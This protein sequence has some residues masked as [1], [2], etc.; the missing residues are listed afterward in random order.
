MGIAVSD[1]ASP[2][3][4]LSPSRLCTRL[5]IGALEREGLSVAAI[6]RVAE[7]SQKTTDRWIGR[8]RQGEGL[9]EQPRSGCPRRINDE[10][11]M[12]A[13]GFYCQVSPLP[14]CSSWSLRWAEQHFKAHPELLDDS[15]SRSSLQR[16][17]KSHPLRPHLHKYFLQITDPDFFPK[18]ERIIQLYLNP[19]EYYFCLDESPGIQALSRL[20]PTMPADDDGRPRYDGPDYRRNGTL[21]LYAILSPNDGQVFGRCASNHTTQTLC[22][23]FREHVETQPAGAELYYVMD[24]LSPHFNDEFCATVADLSGVTYTPQT[25]GTKRREWLGSKDKRIIIYFTPFHGSWLNMVEIWFGLLNQ[26][27]LKRGS[28][29]TVEALREAIE[30]FLRTWNDFFAHPFNWGYDGQDLYAKAVR[31]F[32]KHLI[33]ESPMMD[34][35]FLADEF[36]LMSNLMNNYQ[37]KVPEQDWRQLRAQMEA[38]EEFITTVIANEEGP[39]RKDRAAKAHADLQQV[40]LKYLN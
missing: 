15:I 24:N 12:K 10:V 11:Q 40:L 34:S 8:L 33:L 16:I 26:K 23:I 31:R 27:C 37:T 29:P 20:V 39:K 1:L 38:K 9:Y 14:G 19:P 17:L 13:I 25:P 2:A 35:K 3:L 21:D 7:C 30:A 28:F 6:S 36:L 5:M 18:A 22:R 32:S 4:D